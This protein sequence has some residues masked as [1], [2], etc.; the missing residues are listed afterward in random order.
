MEART[1][2]LFTMELFTFMN[3]TVTVIHVHQ[4]T[5]QPY[6]IYC[7]RANPHYGF[8]ASPLANIFGPGDD[9]N[10]VC[11]L[12]EQYFDVQ[13]QLADKTIMEELDRLLSLYEQYGKL[14]LMCW[15]KPKRCHVETIQRF[16]INKIN[17]KSRS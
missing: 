7:G 3:D 16:L 1:S 14:E 5:R 2:G 6:Q 11:D 13:V 8:K 9:R 10:Q 4:W 12:F 15:C 17:E